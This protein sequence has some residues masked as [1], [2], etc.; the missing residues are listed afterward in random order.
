MGRVIGV[1]LLMHIVAIGGILAFKWIDKGEMEPTTSVE[2]PVTLSGPQSAP[3]RDTPGLDERRNGGKP[4][5]F[6]HPTMNG[7]KRYRVGSDES[8]PQIA[9]AFHAS[10]SE[11]EKLNSI[12]TGMKLYAGQWLTIPDHRADKSKDPQMIAQIP[13][14]KAQP[15]SPSPKPFAK[16]DPS[17]APPVSKP[18]PSKPVQ[19]AKNLLP[20]AADP[21]PTGQQTYKVV[22]G[23][24]AYRISLKY[25]VSWQKLLEVNGMT[26]PRELQAGQTITIPASAVGGS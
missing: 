20:V 22:R 9:R 6:D 24:T 16:K 10:V 11:V 4:V 12:S 26:D 23:D 17:A 19:V 8:L 21:K 5:I 13:I 15:S 7:Y 1:V 25:G 18:A 14:A 3:R 2:A